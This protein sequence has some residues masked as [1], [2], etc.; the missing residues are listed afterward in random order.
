MNTIPGAEILG[1]GFNI[2][3]EYNES[4]ITFQLFTHKKQDATEYTYPPTGVTYQVPDNTTVLTQN[5]TSGS[6]NVFNTRQQFQSYFSAKAGLSGSAGGFSGE[7][8]MAYSQSFNTEN[9]YYYGVS[10]ANYQSWQLLMNSTNSQWLSTSF[11][12]D[13]AVQ[14]LPSKYTNENKECFFAVF[15]KFGTHF[16]SKAT[17]GGNLSYFVAID[18]SFSSDQTQVQANLALEYKGVFFS[19]KAE[20][21]AI[22]NQLGEQ[23]A[24]NR[25]VKV[26]AEGGDT[27]TLEALNPGFGDSENSVFTY[28][29]SAVME[30]PSIILFQL[31][32][33]SELFTGD[34]ASAIAEAIKVYT[35]SAILAT[36]NADVSFGQGPDGGDYITSSCIIVNGDIVLPDPVPVAPHP[37]V[38]NWNGYDYV[39]PVGGFQIAIFD[40]DT[41]EV[42]M[43]HMYYVDTYSLDTEQNVY[44]DIMNDINEIIQTNYTVVIA[45]FAVDLMNYPTT[46]FATWLYSCGA[47]LSGWKHYFGY[48]GVTGIV[49]YVC[50][51]KQGQLPGTAIE[52]FDYVMDWAYD[53]KSIDTSAEV[54]LNSSQGENHFKKSP[55]DFGVFS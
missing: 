38:Y 48:T 30:N 44:N 27:S 35:N 11:T 2:M 50:I 23:W 17:V 43:S 52:Q 12:E 1:F 4:S 13:P 8:N 20:A 49:N 55:S 10:E 39:M 31:T 26:A 33:L 45:G 25:I 3:G 40:S 54:L 41:M 16:I 5:D 37:K 51:S 14:N 29:K 21:E 19:T 47:T 7:F 18:Q 24:E 28:W 46:E 22:W 6:S 32:Q 9:N 34:T 15:R 36:A 53:A 42:I